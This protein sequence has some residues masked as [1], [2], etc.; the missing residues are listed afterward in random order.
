VAGGDDFVDESGPVMGPLLLEDRYEDK[1]EF[2]EK[3]SLCLE[4]FFGA[5]ALDNEAHNEVSNT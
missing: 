2:I 3:S 4:G 5:G 1:V